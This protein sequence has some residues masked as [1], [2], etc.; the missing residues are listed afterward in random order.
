MAKAPDIQ[1]TAGAVRRRI[2]R[3]QKSGVIL[4]YHV[5]LDHEKL[6]T[7]V[8]AFIEL[9]FAGNADLEATLEVAMGLHEVREAMMLAGETDALLRVRAKDIERLREVVLALR[10]SGQVTGSVTRI[11]L[12]RWWHGSHGFRKPITPG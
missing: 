7:S 9:S 6:P 2:A 5:A 1:L 8:E 11:V 10:R 3:L 12:E 4:G